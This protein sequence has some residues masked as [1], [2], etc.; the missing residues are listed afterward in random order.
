M[1][2]SVE[3]AYS[4]EGNGPA[5]ILVHGVGGRGRMWAPIVE[6][7]KGSFRCVSYDLRGHGGSPHGEGR[8]SLDDLVGDLEALRAKLGI[9][10]AH[11]FGHSLG[12]MVAPSY[13]RAY[14]GRVLSVG[15]LSTAAFRSPADSTRILGIAAAM[16]EK[17]I[18]ASLDASISRWFTDA[19]VA[20]HPDV[21]EA[22]MRQVKETPEEV[23]INAF[24]VY[25]GTEMSPWLHEIAVPALVLTG[26]HDVSC[27]PGLNRQMAAALP[28]SELVILD[29]LK[30]SIVIEAPERV[31]PKLARFLKRHS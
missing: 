7:L 1:S 31:G 21:V 16:E 20:A 23:F 10:K 24:K 8:F 25:A 3:C 12:G 26:E 17:G 29:G 30:H 2:K 27:N 22:R 14:P 5:V 6:Q 28:R 18:A 19:F 13:A 9:E 15:L 11:V 4:V